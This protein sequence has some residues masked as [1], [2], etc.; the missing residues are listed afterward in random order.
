MHVHSCAVP[1]HNVISHDCTN[2][3]CK[4]GLNKELTENFTTSAVLYHVGEIQRI[5]RNIQKNTKCQKF[6]NLFSSYTHCS[7]GAHTLLFF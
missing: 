7:D 6:I 1:L 2:R 4:L 3:L 5:L